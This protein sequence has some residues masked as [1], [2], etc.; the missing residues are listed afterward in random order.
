MKKGH[1]IR[2]VHS[3]L[4]FKL[5]LKAE[6]ITRWKFSEIRMTYVPFQ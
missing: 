5:N 1:F 2:T 6:K 4:R 3:T